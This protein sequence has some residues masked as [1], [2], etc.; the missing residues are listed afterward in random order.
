MN[1]NLR[2]NQKTSKGCLMR[3]NYSYGIVAESTASLP[4]S[5]MLFH[6]PICPKTDPTIRKS[7]MKVHFEEKHKTLDLTKYNHLCNFERSE[8]RKI[9]I[10]QGKATAKQM[11]KLKVPLLVILENHC[12]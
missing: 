3:M 1:G 5:I 7:F 10:K 4:C 8:M 11:R 6:C 9:W 2:I 12:A